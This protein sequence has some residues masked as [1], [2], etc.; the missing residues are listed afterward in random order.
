MPEDKAELIPLKFDDADYVIAVEMI[1][2][3]LEWGMS[4]VPPEL[5]LLVP[6]IYDDNGGNP[7][8]LVKCAEV[9]TNSTIN[10]SSEGDRIFGQDEFT[11]CVKPDKAMT[12]QFNDGLGSGP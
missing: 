5:G 10:N 11:L 2:Y 8:E 9:L 1:G 3:G 6:V 7:L 12:S 4:V